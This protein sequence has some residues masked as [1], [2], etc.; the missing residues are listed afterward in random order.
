DNTPFAY[1][2][3]QAANGLYARMAMLSLVLNKEV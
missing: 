2:F 1:Y 3:Q